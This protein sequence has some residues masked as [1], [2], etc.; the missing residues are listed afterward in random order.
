MNDSCEEHREKK[1]GEDED[2]QCKPDRCTRVDL[3]ERTLKEA[4]TSYHI[5]Y[6]HEDFQTEMRN[7]FYTDFLI[8]GDRKPWDDKYGD[9]LGEQVFSGKGLISSL[10][11]KHGKDDE[12]GPDAL[13]GIRYEGDLPGDEH[14]VY[15]LQS[16][17]S[18]DGTLEA[19]CG[20]TQIEVDGASQVVAWIVGSEKDHA[21]ELRRY[22]G[23]VMNNYGR[24]KAIYYACDLG[25]TLN[26]KN[27]NLLSPLIKNSIQY[28]HTPPAST[29][30]SP[31]EIIPVEVKLKSQGNAMDLRITET[32]PAQWKLYDSASEKWITDRPWVVN[33][34]L[35]PGGTQT[36]L[37]EALTPDQA[38]TYTLKTDIEIKDAGTYR[39]SQSLS[40]DI[41]VDTDTQTMAGDIMAALRALSVTGKEDKDN[42]KEA[43]EQM[44]DLQKR[45][46][47]KEKD[48]EKNIDDIL[49][50]IDSLLSISS[51]DVTGIRS[52][53]DRLLRMWEGKAY[54][55]K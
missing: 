47:D 52:M 5:L 36:I 45:E 14:G 27:Y 13:F 37:Y 39:L 6:R 10:K 20:A 26:Q 49:Q 29:T 25:Q 30:F 2:H 23:I 32:Y 33:A 19:A 50:A 40:T 17:I 43:I 44:Q 3:L 28:I 15:F 42:L 9:E 24:G 35:D 31:Y 54:Y 34:H 1:D 38:G 22:P 53:M 12:K 48:F 55:F 41:V 46:I 16:P 8:L 4:V 7:P 11:L 21:K 51:A 18:E